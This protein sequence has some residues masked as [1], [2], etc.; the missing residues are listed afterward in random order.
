MAFL[1]DT[2]V[3]AQLLRGKDPALAARIA[4]LSP[5]LIFVCSIVKA[6]LFY[7]ACKSNDAPKNIGLVKALLAPHASLPF[8]DAAAELYGKVRAQLESMGIT[9]GANDYLI[10]AIAMV[11]NLTLVTHN[12]KEFARIPGLILQDWQSP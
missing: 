6:E 7:G 10:A 2:N 11:N 9:I 5:S 12:S 1:L 8:D 4:G 3:W